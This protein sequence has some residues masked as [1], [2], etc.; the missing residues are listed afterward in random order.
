VITNANL[1]LIERATKKRCAA[2]RQ[3][4]RET[5]ARTEANIG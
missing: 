4:T 1:T 5:T 3:A 2:P